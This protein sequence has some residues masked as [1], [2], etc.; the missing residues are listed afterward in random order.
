MITTLATIA[1]TLLVGYVLIC[2]IDSET[3]P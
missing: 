1:A 3:L 2:L